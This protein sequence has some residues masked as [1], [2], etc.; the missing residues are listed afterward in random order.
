VIALGVTASLLF[1]IYSHPE[2]RDSTPGQRQLKLAQLDVHNSIAPFRV[3]MLEYILKPTFVQCNS[4]FE[5]WRRPKSTLDSVRDNRRLK[6]AYL[7]EWDNPL[8]EGGFGAV[9]LAT[10]KQ[11][12]EKVALKKISK[13]YTNDAGFQR[14]MSALLAIRK[15]G[16]HPNVL[17]FRETFNEGRHFYLTLDYISGGEMFDHLINSGVSLLFI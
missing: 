1:S 10:D 4:L 12:N 16:G 3:P 2:S 7:V 8:G 17:Q 6:N 15:A 13:E 11:S 9:Y 5:R 14:E